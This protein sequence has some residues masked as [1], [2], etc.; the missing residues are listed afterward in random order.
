MDAVFGLAEAYREKGNK[1]K[2]LENYRRYLDEAPAGP[3]AGMA[4]K[5]IERLSGD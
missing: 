3:E 1:A 4:K 5:S 2:A